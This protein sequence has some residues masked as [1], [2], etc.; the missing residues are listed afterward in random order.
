MTPSFAD[1]PVSPAL[2]AT[3]VEL[4]FTTPTPIQAAAIPLLL[5][6]RDLVGQARTGSGKTIAFALPI[7]AQLD[8]DNRALQAL[9]LCP[10][11][12]LCAQVARGIRTLGRHLPE[13]RVIEL[14]GGAPLTP[15]ARALEVGVHVAVGTPG[16]LIDH[17]QRE[18][19]DLRA[20]RTI[21]LDEADRMLDMG[22]SDEVGRVLDTAPEPRQI[23]LF[24]ATYPDTI[25]AISRRWQKRPAFVS[26]EADQAP[27]PEIRQLG[28]PVSNEARAPALLAVLGA[29][30]PE[31][32]LVFC[33]LKA[34]VSALC[35]TLISAGVSAA[36][37]HGDL[38]QRDRDEQMAKLRNRS[39]TVL[40][41]T[42]VA[43]RGLDVSELDLVVNFDVP[44]QP[45]VYVHRVGRTG[46]AGREGLAVTL[47]G[48]G[49]E[50][51]VGRIEAFTH[52]VLARAP[53]PPPPS[54]PFAPP[55]MRTLRIL[56]G[57]RDKVRPGDILGALTGE[58]GLKG[59]QVGRI[60]I[61][62]AVSYVAVASVA[63]RQ[64]H[65]NLSVGKIKGRRFRV[66]A[67]R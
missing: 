61:L 32:A 53:L 24:S 46:R 65:Q 57:R 64:A 15:Q 10:T 4:K 54:A 41:A 42:D 36:A 48:P 58:A 13:L 35:D 59:D 20:V 26:V 50:T 63:A 1:L 18:T 55:P 7:L 2:L 37:L 21:V 25:A 33:N 44:T 28:Y 60:E 11:R 62:D 31:S 30:R 34:T 8:L 29:R 17:L 16:R 27:A 43:A 45:E 14:A 9:I 6:G 52:S 12:E 51:R 66:E 39:V 49:D 5:E 3:L 19:L 38:E 22:F 40:V 23:V 47:I 56:G 67:L